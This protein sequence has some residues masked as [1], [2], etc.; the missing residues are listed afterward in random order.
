M[1]NIEQSDHINNLN[2]KKAE[3]KTGLLYFF[4]KTKAIWIPILV[5]IILLIIMLFL[6]LGLGGN[7]PFNYDIF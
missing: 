4:K 7:G 5:V 6:N 2:T 3:H 1:K